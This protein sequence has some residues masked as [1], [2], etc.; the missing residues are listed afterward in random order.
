MVPVPGYPPSL[1]TSAGRLCGG[2]GWQGGKL[3]VGK[4]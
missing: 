2:E 1:R 3:L 4:L